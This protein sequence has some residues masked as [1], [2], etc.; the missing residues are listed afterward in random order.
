MLAMEAIVSS[1]TCLRL[2]VSKM[3]AGGC[4]SRAACYAAGSV[5][6]CGTPWWPH[7]VPASNT[8]L[9]PRSIHDVR[10]NGVCRAV[11][12]HFRHAM[13]TG[14]RSKPQWQAPVAAGLEMLWS[15][16]VGRR[17]LLSDRMT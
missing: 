9:P 10:P 13:A 6:H 14:R 2:I 7:A 4:M 15:K 17:K 3:H 5:G 11:A 12:V 16:A 1:L 8:R